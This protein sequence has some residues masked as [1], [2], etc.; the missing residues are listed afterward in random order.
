MP[1]LFD[2]VTPMPYVALQS[3]LD[4]PNAWGC[5]GYDKGAYIEE[6]DDDVIDVLTAFVPEKVSPLSALILYRLDGAY[7]EVEDEATAYSGSRSPCYFGTFIALCP[8]PELLDPERTWVQSVY[9]ALRPSM[10]TTGT[11][12][13]VLVE[14]DDGRIRESYGRKYDRLRTIKRTYDPEN[15]FHRNANIKPADVAEGAH[16]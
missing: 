8:T 13:N 16:A 9:E 10:Y 6:L 12:V 4:E 2:L 15:V 7:S 1:P 11:Y 5:H 3:L 14:E